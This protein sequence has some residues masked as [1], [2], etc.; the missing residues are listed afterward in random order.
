MP[1]WYQG[2]CVGTQSCP[3]WGSQSVSTSTCPGFA[4]SYLQQSQKCGV[5]QWINGFSKVGSFSWAPSQI[6]IGVKSWCGGDVAS[7]CTQQD[8]GIW[9][10]KQMTDILTQSGARGVYMWSL[11][12]YFKDQYYSAGN[13][14]NARC[15]WSNRV[16]STLGLTASAATST[17][18][19]FCRTYTSPVPSVCPAS[20]VTYSPP[21]ISG[22]STSGGSTSGGSTSGGSTS[23]GSTSG[24]STSGGSTSGG[25]SSGLPAKVIGGYVCGGWW[26]NADQVASAGFNLVMVSFFDTVVSNGKFSVIENNCCSGSSSYTLA[27]GLIAKGVKVVISIG[28]DGCQA[29]A[30]VGLETLSAAAIVAGW[31]DFIATS[32][33]AW[34]GIDFDWEGGNDNRMALA[35]NN[36][37]AALRPKGWLVTTAPMSSQFVPG[38]AQGWT[39]LD[40]S[41]VDASMPQWY[42]G[43][44]TGGESCPCWGSTPLTTGTCPGFA[45]S[46]L[47]QAEKC[48][49]KDWTDGFSKVGAYSWDAS[50]III[51]VKSWCNWAGCG[52]GDTGIW[53][54]KEMANIIQSTGVRGV[55]MW[56]INNYFN[57]DY[58]NLGN[59]INS[60]CDWTLRVGAQIGMSLASA[61]TT[62]STQCQKYSGALPAGCPAASSSGSTSGGSTSGGST[63]GGSTS[64]GS[65]SGGST[66]NSGFPAKVLG[67]YICGTASIDVDKIVKSGFNLVMISFFDTVVSNGK[68]SVVENKCCSASSAYAIAKQLISKGVK[69]TASIGGEGCQGTAPAGLETLSAAA[70]V[71]GWQDFIT[72]TGVQ[73]SGIDFDWEGGNENRMAQAINNVGAAL[74]PKGWI[75][76]AVPMSSQFV[77]GGAQGWTALDPS[78][79]DA[80]M[81]QWYQGGCVGTQSCPC[82]GAS[83]ITTTSCPGFAQSYMQQSAKCGVKQWIEGFSKVGSFSWS[84]NQVVIGVKSWC[85][86]DVASSCTSSDTGIWGYKQMTDILTQT[87]ARGVYMWSLNNYY[88]D[89]YFSA[90][91]PVNARC[92]WSNRIAPTL[93]LSASATSYADSTMCQKYTGPTPSACAQ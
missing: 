48:G 35:I 56:S 74:R 70:I 73:W 68:F 32:G 1:Q 44:C 36:V 15:D 84:A 7:S 66:S 78:K 61:T 9:G 30:P 77:P 65:T 21:A 11:N 49:I 10:Y 24:G 90:G 59:P 31:Q 4:Q 46:Y 69:V 26:L 25:T 6:V 89:S 41:K 50:K 40:P 93:G 87:G 20:T 71:A 54:H 16:A 60:A 5:K 63:S 38:G 23:G 82:W 62:D 29:T 42:Q 76:T 53:G 22:G 34:S 52:T 47:Q 72:S 13:P 85:G 81:P 92:D 67:G 39:A 17:D 2:G 64:G 91:N 19:N 3:C 27:K 88:K 45:Q 28:G 55:Y 33:V 86:G 43:L 79:V 80:S 18:S 12:N 75:V 57:V 14:I 8:T 37:G 51:G 83:A 58:Y